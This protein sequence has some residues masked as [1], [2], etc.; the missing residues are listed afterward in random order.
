MLQ[1]KG[2]RPSEVRTEDFDALLVCNG[3]YT[4]PRWP[5]VEGQAAFPG[6]IRHS[7]NYREPSSYKGQRVVCVGA[8]ASG[9]GHLPRNRQLR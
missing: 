7:H 6:H 8:S 3:H 5:E 4:D 2:D 9:T 1:R